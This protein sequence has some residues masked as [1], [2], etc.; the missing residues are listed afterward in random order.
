MSTVPLA[1]QSPHQNAL[2]RLFAE[3]GRYLNQGDFSPAIEILERAHRLDS[4]NFKITLDLGYACAMAYDFAAAGRWF[5]KSIQLAPD[6]T[7]VL[8]AIANRWSDARDF[9]AARK[10]F[11]QV[12]DRPNV[13]LGACF[14]LA[15]IYLR[16]RCLDK[17]SEIAERAMH[18]YGTHEAALL[19]Q[20]E[21][22]RETG[23]LEEA[24]KMLR[25]VVAK[26]DCDGEARATALYSLGK[27]LDQQARYDEAMAAL[28]DAKALLRM[29]AQPA[30]RTL[31]LKQAAMK[32]IQGT[33]SA[34]IL[35]RWRNAAD[36]DLQPRPDL[37]LLCGHA[38]SGT[39]LLEYVLD[40][41]PHIV[42][43]DESSV[44]QS[45]AYPLLMR[46]RSGKD[47]ILAGL[48]LMAPRSLR[49]I[50]AEYFRGIE[51]VLGQPV[52]ERLLVDKNPAL[53]FDIPAICRIFPEAK[54][55]VALRDPRDVCLS[56]FM[57]AAPVLP[58]SVPWL[59]L[60]D[61]VKHYALL[62]GM[63]L[64]LKPCLGSAA[65]EVRYEDMVEN[66]ETSAR[67]VLDFLGVGWDER[68]LR[69]NEHAQSKTVNSPT[70]A[71]VTRPIFK[72][73]VG[74]WRHYQK[75]FEPHL[76]HLAPTLRALGYE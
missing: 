7:E 20:A 57:Q 11:E 29:T 21:V 46:R 55:L 37:A 47:S 13:P 17:A 33:I 8:M 74:R 76:E 53:T 58:D 64:A 22:Y 61:T 23:Q 43:A 6:N 45:R 30:T 50:R 4:A 66:L 36:T 27:V 16:Q 12:L 34:A 62:T 28:L 51:S 26:A 5:D 19:T 69:F 25:S 24:E 3:A 31:R 1:Q 72:T 35:E 67:R 56:C 65:I 14:G 42:A 15:K 59:T 2:S 71:E 44:F 40:A 32:E 60:E 52:G 41:H 49:Q 38:R 70:F 39:T 10:A 68:V 73:A 18:L 63:W 54:F 9:D 48:D 75:Y